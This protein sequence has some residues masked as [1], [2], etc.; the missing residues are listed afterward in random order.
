MELSRGEKDATVYGTEPHLL[1][2]K[3]NDDQWIHRPPLQYDV[4]LD[5]GALPSSDSSATSYR[6]ER[7]IFRAVLNAL[8]PV[9]VTLFYFLILR[10]YLW[11]P[12]ENGIIPSRPVNSRGVFF[13]WLILSIFVLDWAKSGLAGFE[14]TALMKPE[15]APLDG[16]KFM[17]HIDRGWGS[18]S[19]WWQVLLLTFRYV[20]KKIRA[21]KE[22]LEWEG[23]GLLW[24]YLAFCS[25]LF[26]AAV[27]LSGLSM[28][29]TEALQ[30]AKRA[31]TISGTNQTTFQMQ[32]SNAVADLASY[33]WRQGRPTTP[34]GATILYAPDGTPDV[35]S[36]F[37][38]DM[39]QSDYQSRLLNNSST[40]NS[41]ITFF[42]GP[43]VSERAHGRAWGMLTSISCMPAHPY[44][45]LQLLNVTAINNWTSPIWSATS[46]DYA[47]GTSGPYTTSGMEP[48]HFAEGSALGLKY[49]YLMASDLGIFFGI[50]RY[51]NETRMP[52]LGAIELVMWQA[53]DTILGHIPD[54]TFKNMSS[55][56]LVESSFSS[57]DNKTYLGYGVRC[58]V[59]STVG[60]A[61]ISPVTNTFKDFKTQVASL[62]AT[63]AGAQITTSSGVLALQSLVF[64]AFTSVYLGYEDFPKCSPTAVFCTGPVGANLATNGIPEF[65]PVQKA[66]PGSDSEV[67]GGLMQYPTISPERMNLAMYKLFGEITIGVMST[68]PG[69]WTSTANETSDLG[70]SGLDPAHDIEQGR[71]PF[72]VVLVLLLLW[73]V[74]TVLP[75]LL[76]P[77]F[78]FERRWG[79]VLDGFAMFR[80]GA[81]WRESVHSLQSTELDGPGAASLSEIPG[82]IG[83]LKAGETETGFV[84]LS[85]ERAELRKTYSYAR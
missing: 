35:S 10:Y 85:R 14:A 29:P 13:A 2:V 42:S 37:Y 77:G 57:R 67:T 51:D 76:L 17:W 36:T 38:E 71:V 43:E 79:E 22:P 68:G 27:P 11:E 21:G 83:D 49:Q 55:H 70:L 9:I 45:D 5:E 80:F 72:S 6:F 46:K 78:L 39:I 31:I 59:N 32:P 30:L 52:V 44:R 25:F 41:T 66:P 23:P 1:S 84:G 69:N 81:E 26:Y 20:Y 19:S 18:L 8:G 50:A 53:F 60:A 40:L 12:A 28:E 33:S 56:P 48:V 15:Y 54:E 34:D 16:R 64:A 58:S 4:P 74:V 62:K 75:Q 61:T 7:Y 47:N 63:R 3:E 24:F 82:M 73:A 65:P